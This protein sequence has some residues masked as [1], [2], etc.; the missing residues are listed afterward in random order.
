R[1]QR[2]ED[3]WALL[4]AQHIAMEK[5]KPLAVVF[6]LTPH[7]PGANLR[8]YM[9]LLRGLQE[10]HQPLANLNIPFYLLEGD[11][12][13]TLPKFLNLIRCASSGNGKR[14]LSSEPKF[15]FS[16]LM[17]IT[18]CQPGSHLPKRNSPPIP[19]GPG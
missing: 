4:A 17:R 10:L 18:L 11:P 1:D 2:V 7:F 8:H 9:F 16:K 12:E 14:T 5:N 19:S 3:N 15:L 6:S 13:T